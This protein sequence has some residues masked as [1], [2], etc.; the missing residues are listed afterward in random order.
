MEPMI[1]STFR[2]PT[3]LGDLE[4]FVAAFA[5]L[6]RLH[7]ACIAPGLLVVAVH[8]SGV[9]TSHVHLVD[10][11]EHAVLGSHP[12]C[13]LRVIADPGLSTRHAVVALARRGDG[14][15]LQAWAVGPSGLRTADGT[16]W[17]TL[18]TAGPVAFAIGAT[19]VFAFATGPGAAA[20]TGEPATTWAALP[21]RRPPVGT[22]F[23]VRPGVS[24]DGDDPTAAIDP[25]Q[26]GL[27]VRALRMGGE[28]IG[29]LQL[30]L[31]ELRAHVPVT[32]VGLERGVLLGRADRCD[33]GGRFAGLSRIHALLVA[34]DGEVW[35]YDAS[36]HNGLA[37]EGRPVTR[38]RLDGE[39]VVSL[40]RALTVTWQA[41]GR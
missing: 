9:V 21:P 19:R 15:A 17:G 23:P 36:S 27:R 32:D 35:L 4:A 20:W 7:E 12:R 6:R 39:A 11:G 26:A 24:F 25:A 13:R 31:G 5:V 2:P 41:R 22:V 18:L 10:D 3:P 37:V 14:A 8:D 34:R 1:Q 40:G 33:A 28:V 16:S 29:V 30:D 38:C